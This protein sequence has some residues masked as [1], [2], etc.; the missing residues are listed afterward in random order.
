MIPVPR[1]PVPRIPVPLSSSHPKEAAPIQL[2]HDLEATPIAGTLLTVVDIVAA[3]AKNIFAGFVKVTGC[4]RGALKRINSSSYGCYLTQK[5]YSRYLLGLIPFAIL[6]LNWYS[7]D[8]TS[9][10]VYMSGSVTKYEYSS[11]VEHVLKKKVEGE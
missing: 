4:G 7:T 6:A 1:I 3:I 2:L 10:E 8:K 9:F 5:S 11:R